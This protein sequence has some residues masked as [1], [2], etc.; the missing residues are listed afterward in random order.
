VVFFRGKF[1]ID[2]VHSFGACP[3]SSNAGMIANAVDIWQAK[4]HPESLFFKYED[5]IQALHYPNS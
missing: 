3:A 1:Y 2:H 5:D 4:S